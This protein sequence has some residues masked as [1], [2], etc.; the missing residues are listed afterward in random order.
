MR[1]KLSIGSYY[2]AYEESMRI[3]S[4]LQKLFE[5]TEYEGKIGEIQAM[6]EGEKSVKAIY[7]NSLHLFGRKDGLEIYNKM[8]A[9][10]GFLWKHQ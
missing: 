2:S 10:E 7:V 1:E 5:S 9:S 8:K 6:L 3:K 4:A